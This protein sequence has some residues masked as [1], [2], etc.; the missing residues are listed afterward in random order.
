MLQALLGL[1]L[2]H[3]L[4]IGAGLLVHKGLVDASDAE[5]ISGGVAAIVGV[6]LSAL[7]KVK[8]VGKINDAAA[9]VAGTYNS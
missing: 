5:T 6:G 1:A 9:K 7:N 3:L 2:R 4:T 8:V